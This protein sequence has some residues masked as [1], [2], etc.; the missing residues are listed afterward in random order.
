M[1]HSHSYVTNNGASTVTFNA[2]S[3]VL[4]LRACQGSNSP[5]TGTNRPYILLS[6]GQVIRVDGANNRPSNHTVNVTNLTSIS[7]KGNS[8][9]GM[10][11]LS[12]KLDGKLLVD[13]SATPPDAPSTAVTACSVNT[14]QKFGI[15]TFDGNSANRTLDHGD[16]GQKPDFMICKKKS[17][18][19]N[20]WVIWH[21]SLEEYHYLMFPSNSGQDIDATLFNSHMSDGNNL[22]TVG[23]NTTF[24]ETGPII[25]CIFVV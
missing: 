10:N 21:K 19:G 13:T 5:S 16:I 14:K 20:A 24:N 25:S 4:E 23:S 1:L 15:Y 3:G 8:A 22:W 18:N 12:V 9:Q 2:I 6:D 11:L 7:I 17:T